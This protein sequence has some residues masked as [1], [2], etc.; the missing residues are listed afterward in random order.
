MS[1]K[2][3][4]AINSE[5]DFVTVTRLADNATMFMQGEE[6]SDLLTAIG[7]ELDERE[8]NYFFDQYKECFVTP[9][10]KLR[11]YH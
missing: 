7:G 11:T 6:A 8:V 4:Y 3:G 1:K 9:E 2:D 10:I 5:K